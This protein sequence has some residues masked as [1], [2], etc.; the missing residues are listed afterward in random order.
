[1]SPLQH[2]DALRVQH[3]LVIV[4]CHERQGHCHRHV[5]V[6]LASEIEHG[7][8]SET[9]SACRLAPLYVHGKEGEQWASALENG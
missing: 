3:G 5:L 9:A 6:Q 7:E 4:L 1:M 2:L 8:H